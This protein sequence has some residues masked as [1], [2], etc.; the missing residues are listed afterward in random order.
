MKM[1][2]PCDRFEYVVIFIVVPLFNSMFFF[3]HFKFT[4][5]IVNSARSIPLTINRKY[6]TSYTEKKENRYQLR[7]LAPSCKTEIII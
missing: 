1:K 3:I 6:I 5:K 4:K 7:T 2:S